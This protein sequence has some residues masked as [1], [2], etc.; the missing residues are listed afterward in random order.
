MS[1]EVKRFVAKA[2]ACGFDVRKVE[3]GEPYYHGKPAYKL[4]RPGF[5]PTFVGGRRDAEAWLAQR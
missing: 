1:S 3:R 4:S 2:E 5:L